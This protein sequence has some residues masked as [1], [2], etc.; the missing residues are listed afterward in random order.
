MFGLLVSAAFT[1]CGSDDDDN[2][3]GGGKGGSTKR[4][5]KIV[6]TEEDWKSESSISYDAQGRVTRI[7]CNETDRTSE[8]T[9]QYSDEQITSKE[10]QERK[11]GSTKTE[12]HTYTLANGQ[13]IKDVEVNSG[14]NSNSNTTRLYSYD[15]NGYLASTSYWG[16]N[17]QNKTK[18]FVWEDG[19]LVELDYDSW[20]YSTT[21]WNQGIFFY[22][23]PN[24]DRV[25]FGLGY[26]GKLPKMMP[27]K[28]EDTIY[29]TWDSYEYVVTNGLITA[30]NITDYKNRKGAVSFVWE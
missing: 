15:E 8:I 3:G 27:S 9:Y 23:V 25:L 1:A 13:I 16:S 5:V 22:L 20:A 18:D 10:V 26:Y 11:G 12:T 17:V 28:S 2:A 24:V 29:H 4:I 14:T 30:I 6:E 19:N 21:P 7:V